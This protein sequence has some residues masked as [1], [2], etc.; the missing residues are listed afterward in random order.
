MPIVTADLAT[1]LSGG[2]ANADPNLSLGGAMSANAFADNVLNNLW[3][4]VSGAESAAGDIEYRGFYVRNGHATLSWLAPVF[5]LSTLTS[6]P[7]TEFDIALAAEGVNVQMA[8]IAD[9]STAPAGVTFT[10]PT[11]KATGLVIP[12]IP[13]TQFKGLWI[14]RTVTA[15]AAAAND[16]GAFTIEGDTNP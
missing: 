13:A 5:W 12:D 10:R 2:A 3:D 1:R 4:N 9:E 7:N 16:S 8:S 15:G 6:S 14:R 11:S